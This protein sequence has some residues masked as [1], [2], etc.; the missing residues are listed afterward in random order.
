MEDTDRCI[1]CILPK[2]ARRIQFDEEG[3]C[4]L[5]RRNAVRKDSDAGRSDHVQRHIDEIKEMGK[6]RPYDTVVGL[7]GGRDSSFLLYVLVKQHG[8]RCL[9]AYH[10]TPF[11]PDVIDEN[12]RALTDRL[13]VPLV[14]MDI[15]RE[16]HKL[17]CRK[18]V[19]SWL[20]RHDDVVANLACVPCKRHNYEVY[21]VAAANNVGVIVFG[22]NELEA[23]QAGSGS[24]KGTPANESREI[25]S[26]PRTRQ[27][28]TVAGRGMRFLLRR[29]EFLVDLPALFMSSI[30]YL[31]NRTPYLRMRYSNIKMLD[32]YVIA[33]YDEA[34][35]I[36][37]LPEMGWNKPTNSPSTWRADCTFAEIKNYMFKSRAGLT[38]FDAYFS[39]M[40]RA[41]MLTRDA[42]LRR[43]EVEGA[44]SRE[45]MKEACDVLEIPIEAFEI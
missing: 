30:L 24:S 27:M 39:N 19:Q 35:V 15:S 8:L 29:P 17:W 33:G 32:Y 3:R 6:G 43:L 16:Q 12:V 18:M 44:I 36:R 28:L 23:F 41:G 40:I 45:R 5:C 7:S 31:N 13:N 11:T 9:A 34:E 22:G 25:T 2:T 26:R 10:R 37:S 38:Y 42:A 20:E 14:E 1:E 21:K 4:E